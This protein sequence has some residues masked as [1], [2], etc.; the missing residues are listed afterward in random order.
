MPNQKTPPKKNGVTAHRGD[1][2]DFPENTLPAFRRAIQLGVDWIELDIHLTRDRQL[3]VIHDP[4]TG[5]VGGKK[6]IVAQSTWKDLQQADA[7][8]QFR[9]ANNRTLHDCPP[10]RIPLLSEVLSLAL[11]QNQTRVS[12][13]PKSDCVAEILSLI[14]RMKAARHVGFNDGDPLKMQAVKKW[15][16]SVPV[17]WDRCRSDLSADISF[18]RQNGFETIM[19]HIDDVTEQSIHAIQEAKLEAGAWTV[20]APGALQRLLKWG[21]DRIY[22]DNPALLL[23]LCSSRHTGI[24]G[25]EKA[26]EEKPQFKP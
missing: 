10:E 13:Q 11:E 9:N 4:D 20:N 19:L 26:D 18:A 3:V 25:K 15:N 5:R 2:T 12:I 7:A 14:D 8:A 1:S 22:T 23:D 6:L 16:S 21:I 17:F 24:A